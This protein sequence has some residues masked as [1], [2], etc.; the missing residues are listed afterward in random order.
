M[1]RG[2]TAE[3]SEPPWQARQAGH[4]DSPPCVQVLGHVSTR[5][6][7]TLRAGHMCAGVLVGTA[8]LCHSSRRSLSPDL[9]DLTSWLDVP[10]LGLV[11]AGLTGQMAAADRTHALRTNLGTT[12]RRH[13]TAQR[14][15][16]DGSFRFQRLLFGFLPPSCAFLQV[17]LVQG[18]VTQSAGARRQF[19]RQHRMEDS[20]HRRLSTAMHFPMWAQTERAQ[21]A[22]NTRRTVTWRRVH[23]ANVVCPLQHK[24]QPLEPPVP[25]VQLS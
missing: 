13:N 11:G 10:H 4:R 12:A 24:L 19:L 9:T 18:N 16:H 5:N 25:P 15:R 22:S 20:C 17:F 1:H 7:G 6:S 3:P 21:K 8:V 14:T 2:E 23:C